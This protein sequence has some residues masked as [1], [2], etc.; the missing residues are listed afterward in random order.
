M[1]RFPAFHSPFFGIGLCR[2]NMK[3]SRLA[4]I[5]GLERARHCLP[6]MYLLTQGLIMNQAEGFHPP[7]GTF[8][9]GSPPGAAGIPPNLSAL[10]ILHALPLA[11]YITDGD[12]RIT[13]CNQPAIDLWGRA[14]EIGV[15]RWCGAWRLYWP[16][17]RRMASDASPMAHT[18]GRGVAEAIAERPDGSRIPFIAYSALLLDDEGG[19][20]GAIHLLVDMHERNQTEE[21]RERFAAIVETSGDAIIGKDLDGIV[22]SWNDAATRIFGYSADEMIGRSIFTLVPPNL[23]EEERDIL[24][25]IRRGE[26]IEHF[27]TIRRRKD[28]RLID[29][30]L[31][32]SP[33]TSAD[34]AIV[35]ASKIAHDVTKQK[36]TQT[37]QALLIREM[38]HR[39]KNLFSLVSGLVRLSARHAESPHE[40]AENACAR[41]NALAQAQ[42]LTLVG[43]DD[44]LTATS[45]HALVGMILSPFRDAGTSGKDHAGFDGPDLMIGAK[46]ITGLAL[47]L[48]E[49]ATNA[50]KYG[51]FSTPQGQVSLNWLIEAD[52]LLLTWSEA[53]GPPIDTTPDTKGFGSI[54]ARHTVRNQFGGDIR[55]DWNREG[56]VIHTSFL[57]DRLQG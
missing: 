5:V 21:L 8:V 57:L 40:M 18:L 39:I 7:S 38:N 33:I 41:L 53:G 16:D 46:A 4:L 9:S 12:G 45:L 23:V 27:Q 36:R 14:P 31:T 43:S 20:A 11:A 52:R 24:D 22:Q 26:R 3:S 6:G 2:R 10:D 48:H 50:A 29:I 17:G 25:R 44:G 19:A 1:P 56:V 51:A 34:G 54:L 28:G 49:L 32:V 42:S 37:Q 35:G 13:C 15:D 55:Y 47:L 30:S